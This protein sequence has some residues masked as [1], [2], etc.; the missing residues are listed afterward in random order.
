MRLLDTADIPD[1]VLHLRVYEPDGMFILESDLG[2]P[3]E[4]VI[5]FYDSFVHH[6][7]HQSF[8]AD[9]EKRRRASVLGWTI[10][11]Y[12]KSTLYGSPWVIA[13]EVRAALGR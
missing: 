11:P 6:F 12:T 2:W 5:L 3:E 8:E 13:R 4:K 10:L 1:G 9:P 7:N